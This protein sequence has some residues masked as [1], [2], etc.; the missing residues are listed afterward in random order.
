MIWISTVQRYN[1]KSDNAT[2][3]INDTGDKLI[4]LA[5]GYYGNFDGFNATLARSLGEKFQ[6][7]YSESVGLHSPGELRVYDSTENVTGLVNGEIREEIPNSIYDNETKTVIVFFPSQNYYEV[8]GTETWTYELHIFSLMTA[9]LLH[10]LQLT[11]QHQ[12]TQYIST[13]SI[14][15]LSHLAKKA[16]P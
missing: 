13:T 3:Y 6:K 7:A 9:K 2:S 14:G 16:L 12:L 10:L 15:Q 5:D 4:K 11:F 8:A 1:V